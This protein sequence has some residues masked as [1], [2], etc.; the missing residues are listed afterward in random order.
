MGRGRNTPLHQAC[1]ASE[2][3]D[4]K[5]SP[6]SCH[7]DGCSD[8][9]GACAAGIDTGS[10]QTGSCDVHADSAGNPYGVCFA[11]GSAQTGGGCGANATYATAASQQCTD[12]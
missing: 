2:I 7:Q 3:C 4:T 1:Q 9:W 10:Q 8:G 12:R 5:L 11:G 6:A